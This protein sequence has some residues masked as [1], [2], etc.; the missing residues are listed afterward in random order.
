MNAKLVY[1]EIAKEN[2]VEGRVTLQFTISKDGLIVKCQLLGERTR[3]QA[4]NA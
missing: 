2:G 4:K 3:I 1:P